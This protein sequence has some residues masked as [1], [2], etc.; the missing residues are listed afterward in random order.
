MPEADSGQEVPAFTAAAD[1][2]G[3]TQ[4]SLGQLRSIVQGSVP[5]YECTLSSFNKGD[6]SMGDWCAGPYLAAA[7][8]A[9]AGRCC[10]PAA[11]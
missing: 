8:A 2:S 11:A 5:E 3:P 6:L 7:P 1:P 10:A 9:D 4:A